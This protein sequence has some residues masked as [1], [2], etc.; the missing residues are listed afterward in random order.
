MHGLIFETSICYWQDQPGILF[1]FFIVSRVWSTRAKAWLAPRSPLKPS[2]RAQ[3]SKTFFDGF[4]FT[5][6]YIRSLEPEIGFIRDRSFSFSSPSSTTHT[7]TC[8]D[9]D[10][11]THTQVRAR[12]Q[13]RAIAKPHTP[14]HTTTHTESEKPPSE[15]AKQHTHTQHNTHNRT[16][17][18]PHV[19][20][21]SCFFIL[22]RHRGPVARLYSRPRP[23]TDRA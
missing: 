23:T 6:L 22:N 14:T 7:H 16:H 17:K 5:R 13:R 9:D 1:R 2:R 15:R 12:S 20:F 8:A 10:D 19:N 4:F 18:H 3:N 11:D 21:G